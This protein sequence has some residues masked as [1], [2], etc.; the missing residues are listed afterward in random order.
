MSP[1]SLTVSVDLSFDETIATVRFGDRTPI[2]SKVLGVDREDGSVVRVYLDRF[3][4]KTVRSYRLENWTATG[5]ISTI[6]EKTPAFAKN[7]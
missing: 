4:H 3:I 5:A 2:V 7:S 1:H 6:L